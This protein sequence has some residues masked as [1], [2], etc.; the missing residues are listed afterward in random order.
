MRR[1]GT[2]LVVA[3]LFALGIAAT[4]DALRGERRESVS[5][6]SAEEV[7][8]AVAAALDRAGVR[9]VLTYSDEKCRVHAVA[10][11]TLQPAR[12]PRIESCK[13]HIRTGGI[14]AWRG[15]VVWSG[16]GYRTVQTVLSRADLTRGMRRAMRE[17]GYLGTERYRAR[18]AVGLGDSRLAALVEESESGWA[19]VAIFERKRLLFLAGTDFLGGNDV[20]RPSPG[21]SFLAV[22]DPAE[23]GITVFT[24]EGEPFS[25]PDVTNPHAIAWSPDERWTALATRW[26]VYVFPSERTA[27]TIRIP[28]AGARDLAWGLRD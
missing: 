8:A 15:T 18:Q 21:G 1:R 3:A 7:D 4:V 2:A 17:R 14:S 13:P 20:L 23:P 11:P 9:G 25:L 12:A 26:S 19:L 6:T 22:L 5:P 27:A 28:V 24:R 10:L 16:L